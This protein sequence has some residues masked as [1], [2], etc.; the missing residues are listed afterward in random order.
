MTMLE[1]FFSP[2]KS[3]TLGLK[4]LAC[5]GVFFCHCFSFFNQVFG[6]FFVSLFF[7]LSGC[8]YRLSGR[9]SVYRLGY[10]LLPLL[11]LF[12]VVSS[13]SLLFG[14]FSYIPSMWFMMPYCLISL[15]LCFFDSRIVFLLVCLV[16]GFFELDSFSWGSWIFFFVGFWFGRF[17]FVQSFF[18]FGLSSLISFWVCPEVLFCWLL[19]SLFLALV[20]GLRKKFLCLEKLGLVSGAF[21]AVHCL[22]LSLVGLNSWLGFPSLGAVWVVPCLLFSLGFSI[23]W[24]RVFGVKNRSRCRIV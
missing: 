24:D 10:R 21:Y 17:S 14:S 4:G 6:F 23:F 18:W 1:S 20:L 3:E 15:D 13:A 9:P 22:P 19:A 5:L 2:T 11:L 16:C 7:F 8:G 12:L